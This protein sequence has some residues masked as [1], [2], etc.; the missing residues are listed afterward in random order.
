LPVQPSWSSH[1]RAVSAGGSDANFRH[2]PTLLTQPP[3]ARRPA[4]PDGTASQDCGIP[5]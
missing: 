1:A 4:A 3:E 2:R 5:P